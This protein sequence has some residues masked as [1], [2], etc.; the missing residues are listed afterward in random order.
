MVGLVLAAPLS[1]LSN[2]SPAKQVS[3]L[4]LDGQPTQPLAQ[5]GTRAT[6]FIFTRTDC[7]IS[8]RYA[9]EIE[10]LDEEFSPDHVAFWLVFVDPTE[11]PAAIQKHVTDY[12]YH[13]GVLRDPNHSLVKLTGAK[14]TPEAVVFVP[15]S[16]EPNMVYRG[17]IDNRYVDFATQRPEAT[18]HDLERVLKAIVAGEPVQMETTRAVGCFI[19]DLEAR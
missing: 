5:A 3:L 19:S 7:P 13:L 10:R 17:R 2:N 1:A 15:E 12:G 18:T 6:V 14:V 11:S 4:N 16:G 8:N 9:P